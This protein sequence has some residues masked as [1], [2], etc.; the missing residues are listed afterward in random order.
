M[1]EYGNPDNLADSQKETV[2][3]VLHYYGNKSPQWLTD[4]IHK[5]V[6]WREARNGLSDRE[7]G[8]E[9]IS[10][11]SVADYYEKVYSEGVE[12]RA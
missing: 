5:E 12:I 4:I 6:P 2:E 3:A 10:L 9:E 1:R 8:R 7:R 11:A